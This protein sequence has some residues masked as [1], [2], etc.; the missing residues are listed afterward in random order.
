[1]FVTG[2]TSGINLG[3][4]ETFARLG[5]AVSVCG[6]DP[7]RL[8]QATERLSRHGGPV[9]GFQAD[10]RDPEALDRALVGSERAHGPADVV[11]C[12][13]A[14]NFLARAEELSPRGFSTVVD[15]DL[16][17]SFNAARL[18]FEQLRQTRGC[19]IF[20]TAGQA[21]V[22]HSHQVHAGAAKAGVELLMRNLALEWGRFGIR[23]N[24]VAP[25]P[26]RDTEGVRRLAEGMGQDT[27]AS[28]IPLE[29]LGELDEVATM[30]AVLASPLASYVTG[31]CLVVD[32]GA[33]LPGSGRFNQALIGAT[34]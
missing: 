10:V 6:R 15:I 19:V 12:G 32:G 29:R 22:P 8:A 1:M 7:D 23:C 30:V 28:Q 13:A 21:F 31:T 25:G 14:G 4:A 24:S 34:A 5:A 16:N 20:I 26:V 9:Q 3:I 2:G 11:V 33:A 17:G 27:W 18:A